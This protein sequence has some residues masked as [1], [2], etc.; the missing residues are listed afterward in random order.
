LDGSKFGSNNKEMSEVKSL[1]NFGE[2]TLE[3]IDS[4]ELCTPIF[5]HYDFA[6]CMD[7]GK[8]LNLINPF[9]LKIGSAFRTSFY[10]NSLLKEYN[11]SLLFMKKERIIQFNQILFVNAN[12]EYSIDDKNFNLA[13]NKGM[14]II[15]DLKKQP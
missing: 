7:T 3:K 2:I 13:R 9:G 1:L 12:I 4:M 14:L 15:K 8:R 10:G 11:N 5:I 6:I